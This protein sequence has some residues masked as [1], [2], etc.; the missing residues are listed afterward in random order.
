[1]TR[2]AAL[3]TLA[4]NLSVAAGVENAYVVPTGTTAQRPATPL[5]GMT[6][7]NTTTNKFECY[8][9]STWKDL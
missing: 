9:G 2:A 7:Y 1:M 6:R 4:N 3:A 8:T 5:V